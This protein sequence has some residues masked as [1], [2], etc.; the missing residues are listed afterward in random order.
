MVNLVV[1]TKALCINET[2]YVIECDKVTIKTFIIII[3]ITK[4]ID[5]DKSYLLYIVKTLSPSH[6]TLI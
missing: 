5:S 6:I 4:F 2:E 3:Y 1:T